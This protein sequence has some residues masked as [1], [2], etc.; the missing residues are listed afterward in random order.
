MHSGSF[1]SRRIEV[2]TA[3][4]FAPSDQRYAAAM[5]F[6]TPSR[7]PRNF[8]KLVSPPKSNV[9]LCTLPASMHTIQQLKPHLP[10]HVTST[11]CFYP[12]PQSRATQPPLT[13][14]PQSSTTTQSTSMTRSWTAGDRYDLCIVL[15]STSYLNIN[16][17]LLLDYEVLYSGFRPPTCKTVV[18]DQSSHGAAFQPLDFDLLSDLWLAL[19]FRV[20]LCIIQCT[21]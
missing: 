17:F 19:G 2:F 1:V 12:S 3:S 14:V 10:L 20:K 6:Q 16:V 4:F 9:S 7:P 21:S 8:S 11:T 13:P 18:S 15:S 5:K